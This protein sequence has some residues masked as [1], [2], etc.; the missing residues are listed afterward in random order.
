MVKAMRY[1]RLLMAILITTVGNSLVVA[2]EPAKLLYVA[3][4]V[5]RT[6]EMPSSYVLSEEGRCVIIGP[7]N[8]VTPENLKARAI[9]KCE[10]VLLTHGHRDASEGAEDWIKRGVPVRAAKSSAAWLERATVK[11]FWDDSLPPILPPGQWPPL[12]HR[13]WGIWAYHVRQA[14]IDGIRCDL[15]DQQEFTVAG[16]KIRVVATPGHSPDHT[17]YFAQRERSPGRRFAFCGDAICAPGKI[18]APF[19]TDWHH[20]NDVGLTA[21]AESIRKLAALEPTILCPE[22]ALPIEE[23][24]QQALELTGRNLQR[25]A[26]LK[27]F[28]RF[29]QETAPGTPLPTFIAPEQVN[30][31]TPNG[32]TKPWT[33]LLPHLFLC[34]NTYALASRDGPVLL[35]D[36]YDRG[37]PER[38]AELNRDFNVGPVEV[39][40][41]SHAHNDHYTGLF[42][43]AAD[44]RPKV[45]V[46]D[47]IA[48]VIES[49]GKYRAP[50]VDP[51]PVKVDRRIASGETVVWREYRLRFEHQPGQTEFANSIAVE[52]DGKRVL[53]TGDN[54]YRADQ[55]TGS[56]GW[57]GLN[58]GLPGGYVASIRRVIEQAPDW[59]LAEHGGAM[60]YD[61]ADFELRLRWAEACVA[62]ADALSK[63]GDHRIDWNPHRVR[64]EPLIVNIKP[65]D[66]L[67]A[68]TVL[69][70]SP[71]ERVQS[72]Y[73]IPRG[74]PRSDWTFL[75]P[76]LGK[77]SRENLN[78]RMLNE[79]LPPGRFPIAL[80]KVELNGELDP[81]DLFLLLEAK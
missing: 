30:S 61:R 63:S 76:R 71:D 58:R 1:S 45:W 5:F 40:A 52:V 49:P 35:V 11:K 24:I 44:T 67:D 8:G 64:F 2:A 9:E 6:A 73:V 37:L 36:P 59:I 25:A 32:N 38:L 27:S 34:G 65:G 62:A 42:T 53:F 18:W 46:L 66:N 39:A 23:S 81:V 7:P 56:G 48:D 13:Q 77:E 69:A 31:A 20:A 79:M 10:M 47:R 12:F 78:F 22:H 51:R 29:R 68:V 57:S 28:E 72:T 4:G 15:E 14:G 80:F 19:T 70:T 41:I 26:A 3:P 55:S 50:Y 74:A 54:F 43:F 16:W 33:R 21:A 60:V 75:W 17:A